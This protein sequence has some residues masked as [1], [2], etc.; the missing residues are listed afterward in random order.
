M[1]NT[2][3]RAFTLFDETLEYLVFKR[4]VSLLLVATICLLSWVVAGP[5]SVQDET[6]TAATETQ[7]HLKKYLC[8]R[9][10]IDQFPIDPRKTYHIYI[11]TK[12][13]H[14]AFIT[15]QNFKQIIEIFFYEVKQG[16][17][18]YFFPNAKQKGVTNIKM[19]D[20]RGPGTFDI[21]LTIREDPKNNR[22]PKKYFS[23]KKYKPRKGMEQLAKQIERV[24]KHLETLEVPESF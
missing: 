15:S 1:V 9:P 22:R 13:G 19:D 23:W 18:R 10:F 2:L 17:M 6:K 21:A 7:N 4:P 14:G 24:Q 8:N 16:K 5:C 20:S 3:K 12:Q 11:F